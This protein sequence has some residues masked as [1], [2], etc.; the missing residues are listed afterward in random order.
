MSEPLH[1][2]SELRG[3]LDALCEET[4]TPDQVARLEELVLRHPE[5]EAFYVQYMGL[6]ADL[7]RHFVAAPATT[8]QSLWERLRGA[9]PAPAEAR[10]S[11][12]RRRR[13][14][15]LWG[16]IGLAAVA[17]GL[18]LALS[19][20]RR[21][22]GPVAPPEPAAEPTDGSVAV[23]LQASEAVWDEPERP[24]RRPGAP[25]PPGTLRLKS[26]LAHL[27]FYSGATVIL[28]GPAELELIS[29]TEAY[30][31][32]GKLRATVPPQAHG[33]TIHSP[34][35]DLVDRGTE[36]GLRVGAGGQT[37][38]HVFQGKVELY[39]ANSGQAAASRRELTTGAGLSLP[40]AGPARR[41]EPAPA[42]FRTAR[43]VEAGRAA[44]ARRRQKQW[45]DASAALRRDPTLRVYYPF[46]PD[47]ADGRTLRD[48]ARGRRE[49]VDGAIVG[50]SWAAGR[51][52]GK[53]GLEFKR[54]SDR[55]RLH[56][57]GEFDALTLMAWVRVDALPNRFH[58]LLMTDSWD[59]FAPHWHISAEGQLEL[60]VQGPQR[61]NGVHYY[62]PPVFPP[63]RLGQWTQLAVV[64]DREAGV[65]THYVDGQPVSQ[66]EIKLDV[67]LRLGNAEVGNWN[68]AARRHNHPVR[69]FNGRIDE[70]LL[71]SRALS[72]E[73]VARLY[74]QGRPPS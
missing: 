22:A 3:L 37:E 31:V 47:P 62:S 8:E 66:E 58:S 6:Y 53:Q 5:A 70:L 29:P 49:P 42:A 21:P 55:V 12:G 26:G 10:P 56:V 28:E 19:L 51:W 18:L 15:A 38:V 64:Y 11:A 20:W 48:Q 65:V 25:L 41:I 60:G 45:R 39:D 14:G 35:L 69:Y 71:F 36:F 54:V 63:D 13:R 46:E 30:C 34:R 33:F 67:T 52:P 4:I 17:A 1:D 44:E 73:E 7:A 59:E 61:R 72:G 40:G 68:L 16:V 9:R 43:D 24:A 2:L 27:E 32:C 57:P 74:E 23:L 50:C